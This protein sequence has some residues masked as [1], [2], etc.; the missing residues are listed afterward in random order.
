MCSGVIVGCVIDGR[1]LIASISC[2]GV[3]GHLVLKLSNPKSRIPRIY[4]LG[5]HVGSLLITRARRRIFRVGSNP[6]GF[7]VCRIDDSGGCS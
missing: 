1:W 5:V 6:L 4:L 7:S 2:V 3:L